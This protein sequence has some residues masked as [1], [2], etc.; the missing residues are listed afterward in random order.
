MI[1]M[2][3]ALLLFALVAGGAWAFATRG[4]QK[5]DQLDRLAGSSAAVLAARDVAYGKAARQKLDMYRPA[6]APEGK[7]LPLLIFFY[8][9]SWNSGDKAD[10]AFA[11][12]A[13][14][15]EGFVVALPDYRL[16]PAVK[17]PAFVEDA[18]AAVAK[19]RALAPDYGADPDRILLAGHSA[20]GHIALMLALDPQWLRTA[21]VSSGAIKGVA[22]L[23]APTDFYP[24]TNAAAKAALDGPQPELTQP[25]HFARA[26]AP[27]LWLGTGSDDVTV[28]PR[29]SHV[30][31]AA[32]Q[33]LGARAVAKD[34][35]GLDHVDP[36]MALA[37]PWRGKAPVLADSAAFL[38]EV[39]Q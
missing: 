13:Y 28:K 3:A 23:S 37:R 36:L 25:L 32:Q 10:Y 29:N 22:A 26:D 24:F 16:N 4:P 11:A 14:A 2:M 39:A 38:H 19:A 7:A 30:L 35:P 21:G 31:A 6:A 12:K 34:Y 17:F 27:P 20:G 8:G 5:L 9:G 33:K 15:E 18:A 1:K